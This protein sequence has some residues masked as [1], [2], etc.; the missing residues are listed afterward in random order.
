MNLEEFLKTVL[1][2]ETY[3][4]EV[5]VTEDFIV[6][7][8]SD[9][10]DNVGLEAEIVSYWNHEELGELCYKKG[11]YYYSISNLVLDND[12]CYYLGT[13]IKKLMELYKNQK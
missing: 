5:K 7:N 13:N 2:K 8:F 6:G 4:D 11:R 12:T 10:Y 9:L 3:L 1:V